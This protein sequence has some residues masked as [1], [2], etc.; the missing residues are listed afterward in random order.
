MEETQQWFVMHTNKKWHVKQER[1]YSLMR[2][3]SDLVTIRNDY[4]RHGWTRLFIKKTRLGCA[5]KM[6]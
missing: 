3:A 2:K 4:F 5:M 6:A 1:I